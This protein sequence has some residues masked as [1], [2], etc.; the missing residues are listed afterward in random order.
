MP[1]LYRALGYP[2]AVLRRAV[3]IWICLAACGRRGFEPAPDAQQH[4]ED[5]DGVPDVRDNCPQLA[6]ADQA[7]GDGDGVGDA[8]DPDP[9]VPAQAIAL[10]LP[11]TTPDP[12][13]IADSWTHGDDGVQCMGFNTD[14][15][16]EVDFAVTDTDIWIELDV[17][18]VGPTTIH[19]ISCGIGDDSAP[20]YFGE[21]YVSPG[22]EKSAITEFDGAAYASLVQ[23]PLVNDIHPGSITLHLAARSTPAPALH[24][25]AGWADEPYDIEVMPP[26]YAG[27]D[28]FS[29]YV[30]DLLVDIRNITVIAT[31]P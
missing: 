5:G 22:L 31:T 1:A 7:D 16:G 23:M 6:N 29:V 2:G 25:Q 13:F 18:D 21:L 19:E 15:P 4:D 11:F 27:G 30:Q 28:R 12:R 10:F 9:T 14:C 20:Y 17:L 3:A 24:W 26:S 8:C